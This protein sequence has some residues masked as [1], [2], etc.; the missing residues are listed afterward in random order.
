MLYRGADLIRDVEWVIFDEVH[1]INDAERGV[2]WEEVLIMLPEHVGL[3]L[4]S[5]TVPNTMELA[6]WIGRTKRKEVFVISTLKR[7]V[8]LEYF[9]YFHKEIYKIVDH[10]RTFANDGYKKAFE[11]HAAL[12]A[13]NKNTSNSKNSE[14]QQKNEWVNLIDFLKTKSLM[15]VVAFTFSRKKCEQHAN[16]LTNIDLNSASEKSQVQ[17]F[18][19]AS[20]SRLK[21]S[22]RELPQVLRT[23]DLL[24]RGI[25]VHH[26]GLLP[27]IKEMVE[28]LFGKGLV[29]LLFATET[30]AMGVNMP[31][32]TVIFQGLRK[33]DGKN[34]RDLL[35]GEF[36]QMAGRAGRRGLDS[37]GV[38]ILP[39]FDDFPDTGSLHQVMLGEGTKLE[40]KFR[41]TYIMILNLLRVEELRV[42]D[43]MKRSFS[44]FTGQ[45]EVPEQQ[46]QLK[47]GWEKIQNMTRLECSICIDIEDYY[48]L[49]NKYITNNYE[50]Q[51][52]IIE[53]TQGSKALIPGRVVVLNTNTLRNSLGIIVRVNS[54]SGIASMNVNQAQKRT[55]SGQRTYTCMVLTSKNNFSNQGLDAL[56][57]TRLLI[58]SSNEA[59]YSI[60][61]VDQSQITVI[62]KIKLNNKVDAASL[63]D[64]PVQSELNA[65]FQALL[66]TALQNTNGIDGINPVKDLNIKEIEFVEKYNQHVQDLKAL[67]TSFQCTK[68]PDLLSH[69]GIVHNRRVIE[70]K[71]KDIEY[72]LSDRNLQLLPDYQQ[73]LSVL[74]HQGFVDVNNT[75]KLKGRVACELNTCDELLVTELIFENVFT[76]LDAAEIV[77]LL[78]CFVFQEKSEN[79]PVL[80]DKLQK[81][82]EKILQI[83]EH[84][85]V[86]QRQYGLDISVEDYLKT[87]N[88]GLVEVVYEWARGMSF[89][90]ITDLTDVL[91]GSIVR[92]IVRLDETCR[93]VRNAARVIGDT[94]LFKKGEEASALIK[95]DIVFAAS[96]YY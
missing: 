55:I 84:L 63:L 53:S 49:A 45:K 56:P 50:L 10:K 20:L 32:R 36:T 73:R 96:L 71:V 12:K 48:Q 16:S 28:I 69:Y 47:E 2:V 70:E 78:S 1:Y 89:K 54:G 30:F 51:K 3:I 29:K 37:V 11:A 94:T 35:P 9:L 83:A 68:C 42:E 88:F 33:P 21:G 18:I 86:V 61:E 75:V 82:K 65:L 80:T 93:D 72:R 74:Q 25:A 31:A 44:E 15:P 85:A 58:P 64:R 7:P 87:L 34:F 62:S 38:V 23:K 43:M 22:D 40:S 66:Q 60:C 67:Q 95:R 39:V 41:L 92:C 59:S 90:Q 81:G 17:I 8:P 46:K 14:Q 13:K 27:I 24:L 91:E 52:T 79:E 77:A 57:V 5:A 19:Q 76:D 6:D 4:L 26:S